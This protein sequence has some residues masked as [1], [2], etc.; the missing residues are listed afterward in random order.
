M[1]KKKTVAKIVTPK[2]YKVSGL[3]ISREGNTYTAKWTVPSKL[4]KNAPNLNVQSR[5][6]GGWETG[7]N[8][9]YNI[10]LD[11]DAGADANQMV[12]DIASALQ[13]LP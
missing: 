7:G 12:R 5:R 8:S 6:T 3:S 13:R 10:Y 9:T 4:K 2:E 1:A 11:Y